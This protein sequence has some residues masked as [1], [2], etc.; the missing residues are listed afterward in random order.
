MV[1]PHRCPQGDQGMQHEGCWLYLARSFWWWLMGR[2]RV[3]KIGDTTQLVKQFYL[4]HFNWP[5]ISKYRWLILLSVL[6]EKNPIVKVFTLYK[7]IF[8]IK[9]QFWSIIFFFP[10]FPGAWCVLVPTG[11][12]MM[13]DKNHTYLFSFIKKDLASHHCRLILDD[14]KKK[15]LETQLDW[16]SYS[17]P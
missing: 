1:R 10:L 5:S 9:H 6:P 3:K 11:I 17:I 2:D 4:K 12:W 15:L 8:L 13:E 14:G 16:F 7:D